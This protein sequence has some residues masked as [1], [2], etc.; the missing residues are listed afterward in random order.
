[1][2][3]EGPEETRGSSINEKRDHIDWEDL[4]RRSLQ[5]GGFGPSRVELW[6][7]LLHVSGTPTTPEKEPLVTDEHRDERQIRLDTDRSFVLYP[8]G[9]P[10]QDKEVMQEKLNSLLVS[11]FRRRPKLNYFQGYH[12]IVSVLFLTL[13]EDL[14]L[15]CAEKISLHRVRDS[16]G[17]TLEP[18]LGLLRVTK[19]L[20][21][22]VDLDYAQ[23][24]ERSSPLPFYALSNL[25]TL[26]S[27]DMPTLP[28]IQH[29]FDY[30][31]CRPPI[32]VVYLAT[33]I[34]LSR[35][36]EIRRLEEEDED[37]GMGMAHSL[38]S[39]MPLISG[40]EEWKFQDV[41]LEDV[42]LEDIELEDIEL[43]GMELGDA[44]KEGVAEATKAE[45]ETS[46][47]SEEPD[48]EPLP[49]ASTAE[50]EGELL[51]L[52]ELE[53]EKGEEETS[54]TKVED[55]EVVEDNSD[56][57]I[58]VK[59]EESQTDIATESP[60]PAEAPLLKE[61]SSLKDSDDCSSKPT[62]STSRPAS[63]SPRP[64]QSTEITLKSLLTHADDLYALYPPTH[65]GL[66]LSS[67]MGPQ[68]VVYTWSESPAE[69]PADDE[70]EA[71]VARPG[72]IV[73]PDVEDDEAEDDGSEWDEK[74]EAAMPKRKQRVKNKLRKKM[75]GRFR[76]L[77]GLRIERRTGRMVAGA[78][79]VLGVA[80]AVY[81][82]KA[83]GSHPGAVMYG[84][85]GHGRE[86]KKVAGWVGG[87]VV[88]IA[89]KMLSG[90]GSSSS[91]R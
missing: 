21:R 38:L 54:D 74:P 23:G 87:A 61:A 55:A 30:I 27:H 13:P 41:K 67:I 91:A 6:P 33:A 52:D 42:E 63:P 75:T 64:R 48:G 50:T 36:E 3:H 19:N 40:R 58:A 49:Q 60:T 85:A 53:K 82:V 26:F 46:V 68:S 18:V 12:D 34:I 86:W 20:L 73:Y 14:Q 22:L 9:A 24:L 35:K 83:R 77:R 37:E 44:V 71:M 43:E 28:L 57:T 59:A 8:V 11:I 69:L 39:G 45:N 65:P 62:P 16:M 25:L 56:S 4:R 90:L 5:T 7:Q 66:N 84:S 10:S 29:V 80:M 70:A 17:S 79:V 78:V 51:D 2:A 15:Q 88:G 72:L 32:I 1:M 89:E 81:G 76:R 31:L 47:K